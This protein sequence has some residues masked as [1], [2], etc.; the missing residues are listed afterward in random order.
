MGLQA[1]ILSQY[2][3]AL[4]M[5]RQSVVKCPDEMW[6]DPADGNRF[7]RVAFHAAFYT[8]LYAQPT[9]ADFSPWEKHRENYEC[10]G[11]LPWPPHEVPKIGAP[12]TR[13]E[14]LEYLDVCEQQVAARLPLLDM[15]GP[16][17][18]DWQPMS[19]L[20]LQFY[21][22]RHLQQHTGELCERL[23][24]RGKIDVDWIGRRAG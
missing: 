5:L 22:I 17:G 2:R 10:L 12:Y 6:D 4:A 7:W 18:F 20:E 8:H 9:G 11:A 21:N 1:T 24:N 16:S 14:V 19:K 23:G 13:A 3:A 15:E